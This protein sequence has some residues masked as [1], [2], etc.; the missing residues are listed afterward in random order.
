M[1]TLKKSPFDFNNFLESIVPATLWC[2]LFMVSTFDAVFAHVDLMST[3]LLK[4]L[5][6]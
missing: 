3:Y 4:C 5:T 1:L 6:H 2:H